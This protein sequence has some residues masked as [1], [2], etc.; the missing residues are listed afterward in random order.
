M[1]TGDYTTTTEDKTSYDQDMDRTLKTL[2]SLSDDE[3]GNYIVTPM[4][5]HNTKEDPLDLGEKEEVVYSFFT[6]TTLAGTAGIQI[7]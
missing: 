2:I 4:K 3:E 6:M 1:K 5:V 7:A